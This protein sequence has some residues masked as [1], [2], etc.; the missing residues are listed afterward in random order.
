MKLKENAQINRA[1]L[2]LGSNLGNKAEN[3]KLAVELLSERAGDVLKVSSNYETEPDGFVSENS[4]VN[5]ALSLDTPLE[6]LELLEVC[7]QI[8]KELG[9]KTKS[10]NLNYSDRVIDIDILYFNNMQLATDRLTLPHPRMH[11]RAFVLEPLVEI[12]PKLRHPI[13]G[14]STKAMLENLLC[15]N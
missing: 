14:M 6:A 12:A 4:F 10:V 9:R 3:I 7:E 2:S 8:E 15:N 1:Y 5:I 13:L 11:K